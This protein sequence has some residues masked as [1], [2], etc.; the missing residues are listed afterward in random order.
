M[1]ADKIMEHEIDYKK[2]ES[3]ILECTPDTFTSQMIKIGDIEV[4]A[5]LGPSE[6]VWYL[7]GYSMGIF[8]VGAWCL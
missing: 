4:T 5:G 6:N 7:Q 1:V 2:I 3:R 8:V